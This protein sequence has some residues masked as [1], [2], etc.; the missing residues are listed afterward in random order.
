MRGRTRQ[1][2]LNEPLARRNLYWASLILQ[3]IAED[4]E[5]QAQIP[6]N[7]HIIALPIED[8]ELYRFNLGLRSRVPANEQVVLVEI[9]RD[10]STIHMQPLLSMAAQ[11][12]EA[13]SL[14]YV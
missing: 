3:V 5:L 4:V 7:A 10:R 2:V 14:D 1:P 6:D 8:S 11:S 9:R 13:P 12:I